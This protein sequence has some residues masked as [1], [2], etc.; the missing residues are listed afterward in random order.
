MLCDIAALDVSGDD[1]DSLQLAAVYHDAI[2]N[3]RAADNEEQSAALLV[4]HATD[5]SAPVVRCALELI[6]DSK[7]TGLPNTPMS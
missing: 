5:P 1:R 6:A 2:Y 3:P 7:W 4:R